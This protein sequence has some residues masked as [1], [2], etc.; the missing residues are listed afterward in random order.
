MR[1]AIPQVRGEVESYASALKRGTRSQ[2]A[3]KLAVAEMYAQGVSS[4]YMAM[5]H[6]V[7][8]RAARTDPDPQY[9]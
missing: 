8:D 4:Q 1:V 9:M 5:E 7:F 6:L 2:R 3:L